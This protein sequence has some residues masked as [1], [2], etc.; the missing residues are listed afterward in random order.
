MQRTSTH[1]EQVSL[2]A[3]QAIIRAE[4]ERPIE[5][6][7]TPPSTKQQDPKPG[8]PGRNWK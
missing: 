5:S 6:E 1:F 7:T 3:I 4:K 8:M 2:E